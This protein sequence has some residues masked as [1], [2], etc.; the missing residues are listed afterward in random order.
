MK[1]VI[2]DLDGTLLN[3]I[4]TIAYYCNKALTENGF[5]KIETQKYKLLVGNGAKLL[6]K[7]AL[8]CFGTCSDED[9]KKVFTRYNELYDADT[10]YL[11]A[12][13]EGVVDMLKSLKN[14]GYKIAVLSNKPDFATVDVVNT[15]FGKDLFDVC[16]GAVEGVPLKPAPDAVFDIMKQL[17]VTNAEAIF[18]G[19]TNVDIKTGK[20]AKLYSIGVLWGFRDYEELNSAGADVIVDDPEKIIE[21]A[22][23]ILK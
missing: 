13:Y 6:I 3:T 21:I 20:N 16:R 18:V 4:D 9:F 22:D 12:P 5:G 11:T 1:A 10:L 14:K 15:V 8:S 23:K 7:R 19:D 17:G 2:F